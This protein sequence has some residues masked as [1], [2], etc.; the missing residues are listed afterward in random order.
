MK[1]RIEQAMSNIPASRSPSSAAH[2][3]RHGS[4][5]LRVQARVTAFLRK[6]LAKAPQDVTKLE[7]MART[8]GLLGERQRITHAKAFKRAK[9]FLDIKSVRAGFGPSGGWRWQLPCDRDGAS[10]AS[11]IKHQPAHAERRVPVDWVEGVARLNYLRPP[12]DVP[13][14]RWRQFVSDCHSFLNSSENCAERAAELGWD[15]RALFGC[16]RNYPLMH[17]GSAG[18]LWAINGGRLVEL[19]RDWAVIELP[20]N[21]SQRIFSRRDVAAG[22]VILPWNRA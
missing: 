8:E 21:R 10:A 20:V 2:R 18:L 1:N 3:M 11:P 16:H 4:K 7:A 13:R 5:D 6:S 9:D 17:L 12:T 19:H 15:A 22:K 14:H